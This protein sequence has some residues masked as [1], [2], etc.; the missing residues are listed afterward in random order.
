MRGLAPEVR[1]SYPVPSFSAA[2]SGGLFFCPSGQEEAED[3]SPAGA[4]RLLAG[5]EPDAA[6][7][8]DG[9]LL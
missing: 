3:G 6:V 7:V 9:D 2:C 4:R 8:F 5:A 1:P